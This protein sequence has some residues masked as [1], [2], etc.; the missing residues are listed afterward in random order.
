[1][2]HA[3]ASLNQ[4]LALIASADALEQIGAHLEELT[5][6]DARA[7]AIAADHH[8]ELEQ[9]LHEGLSEVTIDGQPVSIRLHLALH[10]IV[11]KQLIDNDPPDVFQNANR[12]LA[13]GY[14]R[15]ET[16]HMLAAPIARQIHATLTDGAAYDRQQQ[17][18]AL[19]ALPGS[20]ERQRTQQTIKRS[21]PHGRHTTRR[22][23]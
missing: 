21:D 15:H 10:E 7:E 3:S 5:D 6:P 17:L 11:A 12:L 13:A 9:A 23:S 19:A 16:L 14:D 8:P 1:M 4:R 22:H 18:A 2:G 20:W